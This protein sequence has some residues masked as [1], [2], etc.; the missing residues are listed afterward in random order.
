MQSI[1][2]VILTDGLL[3]GE[4]D[5]A[6]MILGIALVVLGACDSLVWRWSLA[7]IADLVML[8]GHARVIGVSPFPA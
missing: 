4:S 5:L 6:P 2:A 7:V 3:P 1:S 8:G